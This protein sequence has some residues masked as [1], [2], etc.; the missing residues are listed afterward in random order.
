MAGL[1]T[2]LFIDGE[3]LDAAEVNGY[4]QDQVI[5][6]FANAATRDAAFGGVGEPVLAEGMFCY[7][8]D[9]N[10]L[11]SYNGSTWV[12]VV[13]S[14]YP[15]ASVFVSGATI[16]NQP[17]FEVTGFTSEFEWYDIYFSGV[18]A[19]AGST[20]VLGVLYN[21]ATARNSAYYG[22]AGGI[23]TTGTFSA[24]YNMNNAGDF[25]GTAI[26]SR[27]R[28]NFSMRVFYKSG[29]QFTWNSN[30]FNGNTFNTFFSGGFRS[31]VDAWDRIRFTGLS[32]NITGQWSL[33]G[34]RLP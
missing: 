23:S 18:R 17:N 5:M 31:T 10:T 1:G 25:Y 19:S 11:Q 6:R 3:I 29:E 22:G 14:T 9:T 20:A 8:N 21:G 24:E 7:L 15:P 2:K 12:N 34:R 33:Y 4:L 27:Y 26:E 30:G 32:G 28:G 16:T 13:S